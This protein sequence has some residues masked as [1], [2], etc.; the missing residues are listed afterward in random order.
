MKPEIT[1]NIPT[2]RP[3]PQAIRAI[4]PERREAATVKR[5]DALTGSAETL[6]KNVRSQREA[7][8]SAAETLRELADKLNV[9]S[10]S[11]SRKLRFQFDESANTSV[12]Q[13]YESETDRL[14]R[15]IPSEEALERMRQNDQEL[16]QLIETIA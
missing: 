9:S 2:A 14:I 6:V 12:I 1:A 7:R 11:I 15:Q 10:A 3:A 4:A 5:A 16:T 13:V 8:A